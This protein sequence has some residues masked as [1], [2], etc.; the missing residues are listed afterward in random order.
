MD[1]I[2]NVT[3]LLGKLKEEQPRQACIDAVEHAFIVAH[4][5]N[6]PDKIDPQSVEAH[7]RE[8]YPEALSV[9]VSDPQVMDEADELVS[10]WGKSG[11]REFDE[12]IEAAIEEINVM[13]NNY[14]PLVLGVPEQPVSNGEAA[15]TPRR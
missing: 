14:K 4:N 3:T 5:N 12:R 8:K 10:R 1:G 11:Q 2:R 9:T 6:H 15:A 13:W 7:R